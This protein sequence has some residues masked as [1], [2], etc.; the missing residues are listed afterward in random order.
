MAG[1][2]PPGLAP[3]SGH[4]PLH[5]AVPPA[6]ELFPSPLPSLPPPSRNA[7]V[8]P[9]IAFKMIATG[10]TAHVAPDGAIDFGEGRAGFWAGADP[11]VG[12]AAMIQFDGDSVGGGKFDPY[13]PQKLALMEATREERWAMRRAHDEVVMQRA[14]DD[15]PRYLDAVWSRPGWS[16]STRRQL[17]FALWDEAA[18]DGN[19]LLRAGGAE[20]RRLIEEFIALRLPPGSRLAFRA[21]ELTRFNRAR[22][23]RQA[24]APYRKRPPARKQDLTPGLDTPSPLL[25]DT[26]TLVAAL[27][28]F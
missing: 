15:L 25:A 4:L 11:V 7:P 9:T 2:Q 28:A 27:R 13:L 16:A 6:P 8:E 14:L 17:L 21:A 20:A 10:F 18:E 26:A 24:F 1:A 23:S 5:H 12:L 19:E 3:S 22:Q